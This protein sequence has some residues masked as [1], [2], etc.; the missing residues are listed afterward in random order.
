MHF[1]IL[2]AIQNT[3]KAFMLHNHKQTG[4]FVLAL[5]IF[6]DRNL[7]NLLLRHQQTILQTFLTAE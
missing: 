6:A 1:F 3:T 4:D 2:M 7:E 5:C